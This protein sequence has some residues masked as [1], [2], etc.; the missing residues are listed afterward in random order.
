MLEY[1]RDMSGR[2]QGPVCAL[3]LPVV[4]LGCSK[5]RGEHATL[6]ASAGALTDV[7]AAATARPA[8][9]KLSCAELVPKMEE[10]GKSLQMPV[11]TTPG[12]WGKVPKEVQVLPADGKL[13][14]SVDL[15][16]QALVTSSLAGK[17]LEAFYA[18]LFAK[19]GCAPFNCEDVTSGS[20]V[21]TRCT[22]KGDGAL[23]SVTT[24]VSA[25][26]FTIAMVEGRLFKK[27]P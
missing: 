19:V 6:A 26:A 12:S 8:R 27:K 21:Q 2:F 22:C 1:G 3:L 20:M 13:C 11:K 14:G 7:S 4:L 18:P 16:D 9:S 17:E 15:L 24:D 10:M 5:S 23:G 25:E